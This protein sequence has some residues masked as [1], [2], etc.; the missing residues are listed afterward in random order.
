VTRKEEKKKEF[1]W[2]DASI[3]YVISWASVYLYFMG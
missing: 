1:D 3:C 2:L